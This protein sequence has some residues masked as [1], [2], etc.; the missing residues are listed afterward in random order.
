L[1]CIKDLQ[2]GSEHPDFLYQKPL[3]LFTLFYSFVQRLHF[4][5]LHQ[6][7]SYSSPSQDLAA[8]KA[9]SFT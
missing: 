5:I 7:H 9:E 3:L 8:L 6:T 4:H 2:D 1:G